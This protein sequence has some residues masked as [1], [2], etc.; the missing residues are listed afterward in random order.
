MGKGEI[1]RYEQF[2]LFP[3]CFQKAC[4]PGA[5]KGVIVWEWVKKS[6]KFV[7]LERTEVKT[8]EKEDTMRVKEKIMVTIMLPRGWDLS[9]SP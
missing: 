6:L 5:S 4:F 2:L 9:S 7:I 3:Q 1:A 8:F